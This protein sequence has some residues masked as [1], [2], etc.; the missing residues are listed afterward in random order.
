VKAVAIVEFN[1]TVSPYCPKRHHWAASAALINLPA[2]KTTPALKAFAQA[3]SVFTVAVCARANPQHRQAKPHGMK[4]C[5]KSPR[6]PHKVAM[7]LYLPGWVAP[8]SSPL[9][10]LSAW[11][12]I[13]AK[14][15]LGCD[16]VTA[17]ANATLDRVKQNTTFATINTHAMMTGDF[18]RNRNAQF[19][20]LQLQDSINDAAGDS[21]SH[22]VNATQ[23][24]EQLLGNTLGANMFMLGYAWQKG[25]VP[26]P[27]KAIESAIAL[28]GQAVEMNLQAL[29]WGRRAA[30]NQKA[31]ETLAQDSQ[32][33]ECQNAKSNRPC[34]QCCKKPVQAH[35]IQR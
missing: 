33:R 7:A 10:Q 20:T 29:L 16:M 22:F 4:T 17:A 34:Y 9:V 18:A 32:L 27:I 30:H 2:T 24:A 19:P 11:L 14:L 28:N 35:G 13:G 26:L 21:H 1:Q 12:H 5:Q 8:A 25:A 3:L 6:L 23:L 15:L 31:V